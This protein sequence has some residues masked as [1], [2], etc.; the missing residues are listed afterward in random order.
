[1][2]AEGF[3]GGSITVVHNGI[4]PEKF[5][6]T[7]RREHLDRLGIKAPYVLFVGRITDQ[8][9]IFHLLEAA[10]RLPSGVQVVLCASA[11]DTP[12]IEQRLGKAVA[13][14]SNVLWINEMVK[15]MG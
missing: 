13:T 6:R 2:I 4:D 5:R 1:M 7:E 15:R 12:E 9:G 10:K 3:P 8:K 14:Q 11:P